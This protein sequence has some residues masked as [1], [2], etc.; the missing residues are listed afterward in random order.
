MGSGAPSSRTPTASAAPM[1][2]AGLGCFIAQSDPITGL[3]V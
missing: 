1:P 2:A 3:R